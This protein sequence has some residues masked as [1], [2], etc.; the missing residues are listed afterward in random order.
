[1]VEPVLTL[2]GL[3]ATELSATAADGVTVNEAV[4][5][6]PLKVPLRVSAVVYATDCVV[7]VKVAEVLPA[8]MITEAGTVA[9]ASLLDRAIVMPPVGAAALRLA[10]PIALV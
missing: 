7:I 5:V 3:T 6:T 9:D 2:A 4:L 10:V 1:V 8:G